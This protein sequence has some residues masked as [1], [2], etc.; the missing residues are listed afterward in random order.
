[1]HDMHPQIVEDEEETDG[2]DKLSMREVLFNC[3]DF[4]NVKSMIERAVEGKGHTVLLSSKYHAECAGQG[5][6]YDFGRVKWWYRKHNRNSTAS[7]RELS[8]SAFDK[9]V[10]TLDLARKYARKCRDYMRVYRAGSKGLGTDDVVT[11]MKSHRSAL[12]SHTAF[13]LSNSID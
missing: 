7:L 10:V 13:I 5:I 1:M 12:D 6:E 3:S 4:K 9:S 2:V 11:V 8:A